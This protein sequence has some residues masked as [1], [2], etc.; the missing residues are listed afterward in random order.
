MLVLVADDDIDI[1]TTIADQ[2]E[3]HG[4]D[5]DCAKNGNQALTLSQSQ[6]YDVIVLDIM[7]PGRDGLSTCQALRHEGCTTPI[8]FLTARDTLD[9][10]ITGF[11]TGAD[12]YLVKPFAMKELVYRIKA[13]SQRVSRQHVRTLKYGELELDVEQGSA[14]RAGHPLKLNAL[15]FRLLR[16]LVS[17]APNI[18]SRQRMEQ[19]LWQDEPPDSDALRSHLYQLRQIIDKPFTY[20][21]LE[22]IRGMG[23]R[24]LD[25]P[26]RIT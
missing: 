24:L 14:S 25:T 15:Q 11:S 16:L 22:T 5:V 4:I 21:M 1:L 17:Q 23:Y 7:M 19:T 20:P 13:L 6:H 18:V 8:L 10:K 12:D 3:L 26:E 9:D 2:L